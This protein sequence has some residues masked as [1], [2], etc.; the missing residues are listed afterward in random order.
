[1][2]LAA[3][4]LGALQAASIVSGFPFAIVILIMMYSLLRGLS[5]DRLILYRQQQWF[6]TEESAEHNSA[7]E[8]RDEDLLTGPPDLA[9]PDD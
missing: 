2:L 9:K 5:R 8:F 1:M 7:N 4:G 6:I 3:G